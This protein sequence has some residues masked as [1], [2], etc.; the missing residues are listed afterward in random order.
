M[1]PLQVQCPSC[2]GKHH[3]PLDMYAVNC[4][5]CADS[6]WVTNDLEA[7]EAAVRQLQ[8]ALVAAVG[9]GNA[10]LPEEVLDAAENSLRRVKI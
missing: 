2:K 3:S 7:L 4:R 6:G 9:A 5:R 1:S 8:W 10:T